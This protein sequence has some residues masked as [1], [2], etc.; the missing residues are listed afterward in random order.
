MIFLSQDISLRQVSALL[1]FMYRGRISVRKE[2]IEGLLRVAEA[3]QV[4]G[5]LKCRES[6]KAFS[7]TRAPATVH[8]DHT[9]NTASPVFQRTQFS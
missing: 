8:S 2:E 5:L 7:D 9:F 3:L 1:D 6:L 4:Q